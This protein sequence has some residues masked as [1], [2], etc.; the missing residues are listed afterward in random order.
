MRR[1]LPDLI[2]LDVEMPGMDG[3]ETLN[4][5]RQTYGSAVDQL[6]NPRSYMQGPQKLYNNDADLQARFNTQER[7]KKEAQM[8]KVPFT[9]VIGDK[10][11]EQGAVAPRRYGGEDLKTMK[12]EDF[13]TFGPTARTLRQFL[14]ACHELAVLIRD[15]MLPNP[16][17]K[18]SAEAAAFPSK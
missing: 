5:R 9:L 17:K 7:L 13:D 18:L 15:L 16:D 12:L 3:M 10:E 11:V 6:T 1:G 4:A 8:N 2:T 14:E